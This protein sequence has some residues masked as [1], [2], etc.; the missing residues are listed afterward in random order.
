[1]SAA[2]AVHYPAP[3]VDGGLAGKEC[4]LC[5]AQCG[6]AGLESDVE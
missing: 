2:G 6:T 5:H 1:M 3:L 4:V